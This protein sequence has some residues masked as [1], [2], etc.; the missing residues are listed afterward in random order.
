MSIEN[1]KKIN[2]S[3]DDVRKFATE[4]FGTLK[5]F[6]EV[7]GVS[8]PNLAQSLSGKRPFG[9]SWRERLTVIGFFDWINSTE[10]KLIKSELVK[11]YST[12]NEL[13]N[14]K[15]TLDIEGAIELSGISISR[16][17]HLL[18]VEE[19][20]LLSWKDGSSY[21]KIEQIVQLFNQVIALSLTRL[22]VFI[23]TNN[24]KEQKKNVG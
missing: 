17:S 5:R 1:L 6:A 10:E 12:V 20:E 22:D 8:Q 23:T 7:I 3:A 15:I 14:Q 16:L 19:K 13:D 2:F 4:R 21:P 18:Q 24:Q 9:P 11:D